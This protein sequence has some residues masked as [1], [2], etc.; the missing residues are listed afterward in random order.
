MKEV[1]VTDLSDEYREFICPESKEDSG[2]MLSSEAYKFFK[3]F[4]GLPDK[5]ISFHVHCNFND[6]VRV[7]V[8]YYARAKPAPPAVPIAAPPDTDGIVKKGL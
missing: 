3:D 8:E 5:T 7:D 1:D 6:V 4:L 2:L